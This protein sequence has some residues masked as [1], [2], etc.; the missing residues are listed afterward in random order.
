LNTIKTHADVVSLIKNHRHRQ[1]RHQLN[2][3][4]LNTSKTYKRCLSHKKNHQHRYLSLKKLINHFD[5]ALKT[6]KNQIHLGLQ[7]SFDV[8]NPLFPLLSWLLPPPPQPFL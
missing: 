2:L 1:T 6:T 4:K 5:F 8:K 3:N 7:V